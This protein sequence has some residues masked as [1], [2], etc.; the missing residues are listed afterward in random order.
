MPNLSDIQNK[1]KTKF[2]KR[3]YR[4][5][6]MEGISNV[7]SSD[8]IE[9][10]NHSTIDVD[11]GD[12]LKTIPPNIVRNWEL[13]DRPESELGDIDS[14]AQDFLKIGQHQPCIVRPIED[15]Q[16]QY[17]LIAGERRWRA[18]IKAGVSLKVIVKNISDQE[19][20]IIQSSENMNRKDLSD[21]AKGKS[22]ST[23]LEKGILTHVD[24]VEK[25]SISRQNLSRFLSFSKILPTVFEAIQDFSKVSAGTAEKIKQLC[26]K[27]ALHVEAIIHYAHLIR[28]GRIGHNKLTAL[29]EKY[30]SK[31]VALPYVTRKIYSTNH[32]L[33]FT[34]RREKNSYLSIHFPKDITSLFDLQKMSSSTI[35]EKLKKLIEDQLMSI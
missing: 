16:F 1:N 14:L 27:G 34:W 2:K 11:K 31:E 13:H 29:V 7:P 21:Y 9:L 33:L 5:W 3:D 24:L 26:D 17:E 6:N 10:N 18:S 19:A 23:L 4:A 30:I 28:E 32:R 8:I 25:L 15:D 35:D 20:A 22:Y 12:F